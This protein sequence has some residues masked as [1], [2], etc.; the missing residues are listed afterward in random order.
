[1]YDPMAYEVAEARFTMGVH[2]EFACLNSEADMMDSGD[3]YHLS[4]FLPAGMYGPRRSQMLYVAFHGTGFSLRRARFIQDGRRMELVS[5][6][7]GTRAKDVPAYKLLMS[8]V[9]GN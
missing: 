1:M 9:E 8:K 4:D 7:E 3:D 5:P 2:W 6:E